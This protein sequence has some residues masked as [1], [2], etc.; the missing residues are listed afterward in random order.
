MDNKDG[1]LVALTTAVLFLTLTC[2][3]LWVKIDD[4]REQ[5]KELRKGYIQVQVEEKPK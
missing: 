4:T 3:V 5:V 2:C 1:L